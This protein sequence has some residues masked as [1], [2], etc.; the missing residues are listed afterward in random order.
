MCSSILLLFISSLHFLFFIFR[1]NTPGS[2]TSKGTKAAAPY[3]KLYS[4]EK[5]PSPTGTAN[6]NNPNNFQ[7]IDEEEENEG[8]S[9]ATTQRQRQPIEGE[10]G[11]V[12]LPDMERPGFYVQE[13]ATPL[14][15]HIDVKFVL[16]YDLLSLSSSPSFHPSILYFHLPLNL[17][18]FLH[19]HSLTHWHYF[20]PFF[21]SFS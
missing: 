6:E 20:L 3:E 11:S 4:W 21:S 2:R 14:P 17:Y 10:D 19:L 18:R 1:P 9:I 5:E 13:S 12:Y 8:K 16:R 7:Q 15:T